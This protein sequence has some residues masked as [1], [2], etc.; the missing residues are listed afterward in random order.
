MPAAIAIRVPCKT[1]P[2][3]VDARELVPGAGICY[4]CILARIAA[5]DHEDFHRAVY[6][7]ECQECHSKTIV[8]YR[9]W[10]TLANQF[11][12]L[13]LE[14]ADEAIAKAGQYRNT[15]FGRQHKAH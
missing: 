8:A 9:H 12:Y 15:A 11:Y 7:H 13:C 14:C 1:C 6:E 3:Q 10:D 2:R 5:I 4:E